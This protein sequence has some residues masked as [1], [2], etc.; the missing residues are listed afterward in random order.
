MLIQIFISKVQYPYIESYRK[1]EDY[2]DNSST[3]SLSSDSEQDENNSHLN[4]K[5]KRKINYLRMLKYQ[6]KFSHAGKY[7]YNGNHN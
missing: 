7:Y 5:D 3:S 2:P 1:T 4:N 6:E